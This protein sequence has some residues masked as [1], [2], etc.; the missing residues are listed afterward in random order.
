[1][2]IIKKDYVNPIPSMNLWT[3]PLLTYLLQKAVGYINPNK[4]WYWYVGISL[5]FILWLIINFKI[6][7]NK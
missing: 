3:I 4:E 6:V 5:A 2:K 1:M 7:K